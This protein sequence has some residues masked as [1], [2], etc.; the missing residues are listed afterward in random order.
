MKDANEQVELVLPFDEYENSGKDLEPQGYFRWYDL[1]T[2]LASNNLRQNSGTKPTLLNSIISGGKNYG[3]FAYKLQKADKPCSDNIGVTYT[4]PAEASSEGWAGEDIACDVSRYIDG[5][6][7]T[8][9]I[10]YMSQRS[11]SDTF[12]YPF[13]QAVSRQ[14]YEYGYWQKS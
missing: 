9:L 7:A 8:K 13:C 11:L 5:L 12:P 10:L 1:K 4:A 3:L 2:D 14:Y 6:D